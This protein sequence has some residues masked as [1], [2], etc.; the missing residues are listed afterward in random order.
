MYGKKE[1][2]AKMSYGKSPV[3]KKGSFVSKHSA[4]TSPLQKKGCKKKY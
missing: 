2:P 4:P 1:S 3:K